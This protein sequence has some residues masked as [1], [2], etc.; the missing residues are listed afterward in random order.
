[1]AVVEGQDRMD[2][3]LIARVQVR[4]GAKVHDVKG[5]MN[6]YGIWDALAMRGDTVAAGIVDEIERALRKFVATGTIDPVALVPA[7]VATS[8]EVRLGSQRPALGAGGAT[9]LSFPRA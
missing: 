2:S 5:L 1:M 9:C 8:G 7:V 6:A 3:R 4:A